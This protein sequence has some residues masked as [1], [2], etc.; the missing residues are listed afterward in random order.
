MI[1]LGLCGWL[2]GGHHFINGTGTQ[3]NIVQVI[4]FIVSGSALFFAGI[5]VLVPSNGSQ[6]NK[7]AMDTI[8]S[9]HQRN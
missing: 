8:K 9:D 1:I 3:Q 5:N 2:I 6:L 7:P 4:I